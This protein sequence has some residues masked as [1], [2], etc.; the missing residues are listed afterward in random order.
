MEY[1]VKYIVNVHGKSSGKVKQIETMPCTE[2]QS[3]C[4]RYTDG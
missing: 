1:A 4:V 2:G 3:Y